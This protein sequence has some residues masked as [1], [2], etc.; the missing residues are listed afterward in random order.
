MDKPANHSFD[1]VVHLIR[2]VR[3]RTFQ[4]VNT[5]L[6]D[7]YWQVGE[8]ISRKIEVDGWGKAVVQQLADYL[9]IV[10]PNVRGFSAQNIW[11]MRQF[12]ETYRDA[13]IL[14]PLVRELPWT[15]NMVIL[16]RCKHPEERE[17]YLHAAA[18]ENWSKRELEHQIR[19]RPLRTH[20]P[21]PSKGVT[22][23]VAT[24][25]LGRIR[26]QGFLP[27]RFPQPAG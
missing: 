13:P 25:S 9:F 4:T 23:G 5:A 2:T 6:I 7:L 11:R 26:I 27:A 8:Y 17:F 24:L 1:E 15:H 18:R 21:F 3:Q 12:Y 14:S 19:Q 10:Q 16:S 22:A 20:H